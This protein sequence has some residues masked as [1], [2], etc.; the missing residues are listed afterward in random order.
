MKE[1]TSFSVEAPAY[2]PHIQ[3]P[4]GAA[5]M[6]PDEALFK[7]PGGYLDESGLTH[8]EV[9]LSPLTGEDEYVVGGTDRELCRA[10]V[11]TRLLARCVKSLGTRTQVSRA[12]LA[13]LTVGQRDFLMLKLRELTVGHKVACV[14]R[15]PAEGCR[16]PMDLAFDTSALDFSAPSLG[17]RFVTATLTD[18]DEDAA[19]ADASQTI[20][21]RLPNGGDQQALAGLF[22]T[23]PVAAIDALLARCLRRVGDCTEIDE[24]FVAALSPAT[25]LLID[26]RMEQFSPQVECEIEAQCPE[27]HTPFETSLDLVSH[28]LEE[29]RA[30]FR[31][32]EREVHFLAWHYHWSEQD[33]LSMNRSRRRRYVALVQQEVDRLNQVW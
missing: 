9:K 28:F 7:L 15:C 31:N 11:V 6:Y 12:L 22:S 10:E 26:A 21:F 16:E 14:L 33:I 25:R 27:C 1:S 8:T 23:D 30:G 29:L 13:D 5:A 24:A 20:E 4:A 3:A 19:E 32:L 2:A 17:N 18:G